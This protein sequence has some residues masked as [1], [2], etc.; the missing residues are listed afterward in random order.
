MDSITLRNRQLQ[1]QV[2]PCEGARISSLKNLVSGTEF[3]FQQTRPSL[4]KP[5]SVFAD[6]FT[7][8]CAGIEE[9]LPTL[10]RSSDDTEGG[11]VPDHGDFWQLPWLVEALT[12]ETVVLSAR[13][14]SRPLLFQK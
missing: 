1:I 7:G 5:P 4:K 12:S 2:V 9:C 13:G 14:F 10:A 3:L 8:A 6:F 11:A